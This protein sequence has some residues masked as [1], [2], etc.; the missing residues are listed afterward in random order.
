MKLSGAILCLILLAGCSGASKDPYADW[1]A[2]EIYDSARSAMNAGEFGEAVKLF[3]ALEARYPFGRYALQTQLDIAYAYYKF[4]EM[5][6]AIAAADRFIKFNPRHER[7]DYAYYLKGLAHFNRGRG[8]FESLSPR[9]FE[10]ID[11]TQLRD[12]YRAF[13]TLLRKFPD[14]KYAPDARQRMV[15]LRNKQAEH[16]LLVANY[17]FRRAAFAGAVNRVKYLINHMD[18][19]PVVPDALVLMVKAYREMGLL[20][21]A[22]DTLTVLK[23]NYPEHP[24][25]ANLT[26]GDPAG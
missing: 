12:S 14:S 19:A 6:S 21:L 20:D 18:G 24:E 9:R 25:L 4:D 8:L 1:T 2:K 16:E 23:I 26:A 5:E 15:Y 7:V 13:D 3:E 10:S 22:A 11:Q 17:Y